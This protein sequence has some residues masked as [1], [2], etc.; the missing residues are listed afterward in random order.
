MK[1]KEIKNMAQKFAKLEQ[2]IQANESPEA[3][4]RA[5]AEQMKLSKNIHNLEDMMA[6]DEL[7]IEILH[8]N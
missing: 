3:V 4:A 1:Q 8:K 7:V 6:I 2:I 5:Q